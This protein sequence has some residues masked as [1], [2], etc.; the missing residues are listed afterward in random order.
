[1]NERK[2]KTRHIFAIAAALI[3]VGVLMYCVP[4]SLDDWAWGGQ[5][6]IDR[7]ETMFKGYNG[8]YFGNFLI[9]AM[10]RSKIFRV[11]VMTV[12]TVSIPMIINKY[13]DSKRIIYFVVG[14]VLLFL[15]P[16][17]VYGQTLGW[18]SGFSNY[19]PP[20][21]ASLFYLMLV[22]NIWGKSKPEYKKYVTVVTFCTGIFGA[23]FM[24]YVTLFN[25]ALGV[26]VILF[27]YLH[28]KKF[29]AAHIGFLAGSIVGAGIMFSNSTYLNILNKSDEANY[30]SVAGAGSGLL[31]TLVSNAKIIYPHLV[32]NNVLINVIMCVLLLFIVSAS[33]KTEKSRKKRIAIIV[34]SAV[35]VAYVCFDILITSYS[36]WAFLSLLNKYLTDGV[37]GLF[38]MLF[39]FALAVTPLLCVK[40]TVRAIRI[41]SPI[42]F[43]FILTVPLFV[44]KPL[45][46]R[47]FFPQYVMFVL[48]SLELLRYAIGLRKEKSS[49]RF[50]I[51][52]ISALAACFTLVIYYGAIYSAIHYVDV[53]R[54]DYV[55]AQVEK[56]EKEVELPK[57]PYASVEYVWGGTFI[58]DTMWED[59]YKAFYNIDESV[60]IVP[61]DFSKFDWDQIEK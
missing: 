44:V 23:L 9:L 49:H 48:Y 56:G 20:I 24:E 60:D 17:D 12:V 36:R 1:M 30:R 50:D 28:F 6:G 11:A 26:L 45:N 18:A 7:F 21:A 33:L 10:A 8:R 54:T 55:L 19:V 47:C 13:F 34:S 53:T 43:I 42:L 59:R 32:E 61:V 3:C 27:V 25:V 39:L 58:N 29:C 52:K 31:E 2:I 15:I 40:D 4:L 37:K 41:A 38:A 14:L 5:I 51:I 46:A 22:N 16:S 35:A 57:Y